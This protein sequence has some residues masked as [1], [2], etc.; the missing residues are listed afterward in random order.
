M[1]YYKNHMHNITL[2]GTKHSEFGKCTSDEL[3][4]ILESINPEVIFEE[5]PSI[6]FDML[7]SGKCNFNGLQKNVK[8][9]L[10]SNLLERI[11]NLPA[12]EFPLE[13]N[14][15]KKYLQNH[16]VEH[17]PV[18]I[19]VNQELS[20]EMEMILSEFNK[21]DDVYKK[22]VNE[23]KLLTEQ[24]GFNYLNSKKHLV[25]HDKM[26]IRKK[27]L[28]E[29]NCFH[30]DKLFRFHKEVLDNRENAMLKNIYNY[31]KVNQYNQA[32]FLIGAGHRKSITQ[33]II[34]Y[35]KISEIK[36]NWTIYGSKQKTC[37]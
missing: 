12:Y 3:Y 27:Q 34:E 1:D 24:Y 32:V 31:S 11:S 2:I 5:M 33:K 9:K 14:C 13:L 23:D 29:S 19:D 15:I 28:I 37:L 20:S 7:Y 8:H 16:N 22:L 21:H 35:E 18:D 25:L 26:D 36:L 6:L 10:S 30:K 17:F 4:K